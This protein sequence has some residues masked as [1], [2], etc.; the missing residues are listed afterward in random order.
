MSSSSRD[1]D[2]QQAR[3]DLELATETAG[4][5]VRDVIRDTAAAFA[6]IAASEGE[7]DHAVFDEHLNAL[8][9]ARRESDAETADRLE[10]AIE[11]AES[12]RQSLEHA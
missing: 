9:Q 4:D 6:E 8:R 7:A 1:A 12:Y 3:A 5:D 10:G 2:L 11:H